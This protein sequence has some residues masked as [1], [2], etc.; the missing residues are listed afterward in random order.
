MEGRRCRAAPPAPPVT[1]TASPGT[2]SGGPPGPASPPPVSH[3]L[4]TP[5]P[6]LGLPLHYSITSGGSPEAQ[7]HM[8]NSPGVYSLHSGTPGSPVYVQSRDEHLKAVSSHQ[9]FLYMSEGW[10]RVSL[11][12]G[13]SH[14]WIQA[15][16]VGTLVNGLDNTQSLLTLIKTGSSNYMEMLEVLSNLT[17]PTNKSSENSFLNDMFSPPTSGWLYHDGNKWV[18]DSTLAVVPKGGRILSPQA[19]V[20]S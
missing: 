8:R 9:N 6:V 20:P 15:P 18:E 2:S 10:W 16:A 7:R 19:R 5:P 14:A 4:L 17:L 3:S 11:S 1:P 13:S 12:P